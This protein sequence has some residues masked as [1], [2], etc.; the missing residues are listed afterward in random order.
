MLKKSEMNFEMYHLMK[1]LKKDDRISWKNALNKIHM[2]AIRDVPL[3]Y[4]TKYHPFLNTELSILP[5][6]LIPRNETEDYAM[7][8]VAHIKSFRSENSEPIQILDLCT[9]SGCIAIALASNIKQVEVT[10][11]DK[12]RKCFINT[13]INIDR[14]SSTMESLD[15]KV[16]IKRADLFG[17]DFKLEQKYDLIISNP[18]YIPRNQINKVDK[19]V[20]KFENHDALF[21]STCIRN[22]TNFHSR[23]LY[24]SQFLLRKDFVQSQHSLP[25][26]VLEID[27]KHQIEPLK[28]V[29]KS[30]NFQKYEF[31]NDMR[32]IP[33][34]LW[35]Y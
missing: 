8:L 1:H 33:R 21:P 17:E 16:N 28:R 14:N 12:S 29:L 4:I 30:L 35:I 11:I 19:N 23:I 27:G 22:G 6:V 15:S 24:L 32:N 26:I 3:S 34:S 18:P 2:L 10:A 25:K 7:K 13:K 31:R 9:G 20:L 5:R